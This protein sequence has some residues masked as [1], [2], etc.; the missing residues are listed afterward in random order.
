[1]HAICAKRARLRLQTTVTQ[2]QVRLT[3]DFI[4]FAERHHIIK[5]TQPYDP[6]DPGR[7][8]LR[9]RPNMQAS[10]LAKKGVWWSG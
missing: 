6:P 2:N 7:F 8:F 4:P 3:T 9:H 1:M 5:K 10:K